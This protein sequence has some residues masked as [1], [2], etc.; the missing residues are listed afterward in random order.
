MFFEP[1]KLFSTLDSA[2]K[3]AF[4]EVRD[5]DRRKR[6]R[7]KVRCPI[8]IFRETDQEAVESVTEN[9]SS[10]GFFCFSEIV[11]T[12]GEPLT[13]TI[14]IQ[15]HDSRANEL[16]LLC[17]ARVMRVEHTSSKATTGIACH[18]EDYRCWPKDPDWA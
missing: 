17:K 9:L 18:I 16:T 6:T 11:F 10:A 1:L 5:P 3:L 4:P 14:R 8:L 7:S 13:C 2:E 12:C 15:Q